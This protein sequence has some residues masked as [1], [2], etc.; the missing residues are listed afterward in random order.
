M[1]QRETNED[2]NYRGSLPFTSSCFKIG[3]VATAVTKKSL[4]GQIDLT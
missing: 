3:G 4:F 2:E 1:I